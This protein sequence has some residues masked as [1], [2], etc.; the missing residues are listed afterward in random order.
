MLQYFEYFS[1][2]ISGQLPYNS[3]VVQRMHFGALCDASRSQSY[4]P[5]LGAAYCTLHRYIKL[6]GFEHYLAIGLLHPSMQ[7]PGS[8]IHPREYQPNGLLNPRPALCRVH[9]SRYDHPFRDPTYQALF[10]GANTVTGPCH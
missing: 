7:S 2:I 10:L 8:H 1:S 3:E 6:K 4:L 9:P 5:R